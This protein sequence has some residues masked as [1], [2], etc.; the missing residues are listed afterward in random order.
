[1][2]KD[3]KL[4]KTKVLLDDTV[5]AL[6]D[7]IK[8]LKIAD[9]SVGGWDTVNAYRAVPVADE[10]SLMR[11][12]LRHPVSNRAEKKEKHPR[13]DLRDKIIEQRWSISGNYRK[14]LQRLHRLQN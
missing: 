13:A 12:S 2:L 4:E 14:W 11:I 3:N 6:A 10:T 8:M 9:T 1:M 5:S 7:R